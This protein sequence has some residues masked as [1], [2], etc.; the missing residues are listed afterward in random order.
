VTAIAATM[1]ACCTIACFI[2]F[3]AA[4]RPVAAPSS[5][6]SNAMEAHSDFEHL[7]DEYPS[8][9]NKQDELAGRLRSQARSVPTQ[10]AKVWSATTVERHRLAAYALLDGMEELSI[11]PLL[12]AGPPK[13]AESVSQYLEMVTNHAVVLRRRIVERLQPL[14]DDRR[15]IPERGSFGP[16]PDEREQ[17][18]R[19]CDEA[20]LKIRLLM[21][22][23][24]DDVESEAGNRAVFL[25]MSE[26][27]RDAEIRRARTTGDWDHELQPSRGA[28]DDAP[29]HRDQP[30]KR[31]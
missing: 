18:R 31:D 10:A 4:A 3:Q 27:A 6:G 7:L 11:V 30:L 17:R 15:P 28:D 12:E 25:F 5:S 21:H 29:G 13:D 9:P 20:Y 22:A 1:L 23:G 26:G 8:D 16:T 2:H 24:Q 19:V 14:L